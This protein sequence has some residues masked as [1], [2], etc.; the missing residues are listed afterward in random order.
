[1]IAALKSLYE[2]AIAPVRQNIAGLNREHEN[3]NGLATF[4]EKQLSKESVCECKKGECIK[5]DVEEEK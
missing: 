1:V 4:L 2:K 3:I 5:D